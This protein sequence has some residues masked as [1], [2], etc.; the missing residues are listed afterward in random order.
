M[1]KPESLDQRTRAVVGAISAPRLEPYL[2]VAGGN[3]REALRLYQWNIDLSGAVYETL[4]VFEVFLRNGIDCCLSEWNASQTDQTAGRRH[5]PEWLLDP[6]RLLR[7]LVGENIARATE[8]A[9]IAHRGNA[10][11]T[12]THPDVVAQL[13]FGTWRYLLPDRDP[14]RRR[15]W[16][17]AL[18]AAFP[19]LDGPPAG[20]V[21]RVDGAYRL[22]NR[23][24]HLEPLLSAGLIRKELNG[25]RWVLAAINP[26]LE[27]W[28]VSRQR[29]TR[30]LRTRQA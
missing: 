1:I 30:I 21:A 25:M 22:R 5:E 19:N 11:R 4:H 15:L 24:A 10:G 17:D 29:V 20:L 6:A 16:A 18:H 23:V 26:D 8:Q 28:F 7:R 9:R 2:A 13:S 14:G 27:A 12:V 3:N